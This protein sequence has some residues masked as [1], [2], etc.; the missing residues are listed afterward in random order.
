MQRDH[1]L[2]ATAIVEPER[3]IRVAPRAGEAPRS[4]SR[5][6]LS[7]QPAELGRGECVQDGVDCSVDRHHENNH[8]DG[9]LICKSGRYI[10]TTA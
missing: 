4:R 3:R 8:P 6:N 5:E 7:K 2:H 9:Y 10:E 1:G